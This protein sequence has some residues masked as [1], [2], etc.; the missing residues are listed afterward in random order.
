MQSVVAKDLTVL[1]S[2]ISGRKLRLNLI[3]FTHAEAFYEFYMETKVQNFD[4]IFEP[5]HPRV[6][7][8]ANCSS[9]SEA[10]TNQ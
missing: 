3:K 8:V 9:L 6:D 2:K 1:N 10:S 7:D 4:A 5:C